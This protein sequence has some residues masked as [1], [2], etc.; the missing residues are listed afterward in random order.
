MADIVENKPDKFMSD[1]VNQKVALDAGTF[2]HDIEVETNVSIRL[3]VYVGY[4][5]VADLGSHD[6]KVEW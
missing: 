3:Q 2:S 1:V 5:I 4:G 6:P